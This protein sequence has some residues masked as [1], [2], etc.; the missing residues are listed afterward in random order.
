MP[1]TDGRG[2]DIRDAD[3]D[4]EGAGACVCE[5]TPTET[6][7][8]VDLAGVDPNE[9]SIDVD[10]DFIQIFAPIDEERVEGEDVVRT[11][12]QIYGSIPLPEGSDVDN[13]TAMLVHGHLDI[14]IP[15]MA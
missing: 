14:V 2:G 13:L 7:V 9:V 8:H 12:G 6:R 15:K 4:I 5:E 11:T 1:D 10:D 3:D